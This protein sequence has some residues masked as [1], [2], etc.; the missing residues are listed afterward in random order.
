MITII[1]HHASTAA[2]S[3]RSDTMKRSVAILLI[4]LLSTTL[5][6]TFSNSTTQKIEATLAPHLNFKVDGTSWIPK[7]VD[8]S[9]MI[10]LLYKG[11]T[12]LP[13]RSLLEDKGVTVD[14]DPQTTTVILDYSTMKDRD[15]STPL[16]IKRTNPNSTTEVFSIVRNPLYENT[17]KE[18]A[19][20]LYM[21][22]EFD[23]DEKTEI[24]INGK[25]STQ[26]LEELAKSDQVLL[27]GESSV[28]TFEGEKRLL[29]SMNLSILE[30]SGTGDDSSR[31]ASVEIE[32]S[33]PPWKI[34][35]TIR[36]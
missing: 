2:L 3:G 26:S 18:G 20:P 31:K 32:I 34:K 33:G 28:F 14:Y 11:R 24:M 16:L 23:I 4:L 30:D 13:V 8:G 10:P 36:F 5:L 6:V 19:N 35:I 17:G 25:M 12:Y 7:D 1:I 9:V 22:Y 15:K 27:M 29:K 21:S